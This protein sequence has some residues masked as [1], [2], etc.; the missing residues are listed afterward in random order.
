MISCSLGRYAATTT[1]NDGGVDGAH[2]A[3]ARREAANVS[4]VSIT[5][6]N[7]NAAATSQWNARN[8]G[9]SI[10]PNVAT[11]TAGKA[12]NN[13]DTVASDRAGD[14]KQERSRRRRLTG[15][16]SDAYAERDA[17][18]PP[19]SRQADRDRPA[20]SRPH[21]RPRCTDPSR[22]ARRQRPP[23]SRD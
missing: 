20:R 23:R 11:I 13:T 10:T 18:P 6:V 19:T 15:P 12:M 17:T 4:S 14:A 16:P 21:Q 9:C 22:P 1:L 8:A 3:C 2:A 7:R 5:D